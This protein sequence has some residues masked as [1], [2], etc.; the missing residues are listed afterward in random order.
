MT[1]F[2]ILGVNLFSALTQRRTHADELKASPRLGP[3]TPS[4]PRPFLAPEVGFYDSLE[5]LRSKDELFRFELSARRTRCDDAVE[6]TRVASASP[7]ARCRLLA[8]SLHH[9]LF[10]TVFF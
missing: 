1:K 6:D 10:L 9:S 3:S 4:L 5:L 2:I 7:C 8:I